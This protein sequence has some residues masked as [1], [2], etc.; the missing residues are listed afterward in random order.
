MRANATG[1]CVGVVIGKARV[2]DP[3]KG[4]DPAYLIRLLDPAYFWR[5]LFG[6]DSHGDFGR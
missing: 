2:P 6:G 1:T 3:R 4:L 5:V